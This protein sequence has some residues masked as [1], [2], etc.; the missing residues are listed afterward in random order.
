MRPA[1]SDR[2]GDAAYGLFTIVPPTGARE[3]LA[4]DLVLL[5]DVSGSM[6]GRPLA[7]LKT[8]VTTLIDSLHDDDR[9]EMVAFSSR[10]VRY[11]TAPVHTVPE[12]RRKAREWISGLQAGGGTELISAIHEALRPLRA[13]A[14][15]QVVVV[16]D[17]LVGFEST[18]VGRFETLC[19]G[20]RVSTPWAW[21][22]VQPCVPPPGGGAG[23]GIEILSPR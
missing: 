22:G 16:T 8:V 10:Q 17:G 18:A 5:L 7:H 9:I 11:R 21:I 13:D 6:A 3:T 23:R 4:R 20:C 15:R 19:H 2:T 14:P 1:V 12:E